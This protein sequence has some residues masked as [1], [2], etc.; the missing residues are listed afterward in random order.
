MIRV[1]KSLEP[2][3]FSADHVIY[4]ELDEVNEILFIESGEYDIGYEVNKQERFKMRLEGRTVIGAFNICFNKRQIFIHKTKTE[5]KGYSIRK[6]KW[7]IIM[8]DF[9]EFF[10]ILKRKVLFEYITY[11]RRPI[12]KYKQQEI[13]HF[14]QR[15]D[16]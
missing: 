15:A 6:G 12:I 10:S 4:K 16:F 8:D 14:N 9:S 2:R 13:V 7:K 5:C 3:I 1:L 11:I